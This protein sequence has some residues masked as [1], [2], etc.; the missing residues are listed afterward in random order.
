MSNPFRDKVLAEYVTQKYE[1]QIAKKC[2]V[3]PN[4]IDDFW[5]LNE[6]K[7]DK[8][9]KENRIRQR[10]MVLIYAGRIDKNKN[11]LLT[12]DM[13][14]KLIQENWNIKYIVVGR[15]EDDGVFKQLIRNSFVEYH[16]QTNQENLLS[17][18][19]KSDIFIMP[20]KS[21]TFG[22]VY[23]EAMSQ[24]LPVIYTRGQGFDG[25]YEEGVVGYSV[26]ANRT[27]D[28][29]RAIEQICNNYVT[30]SRTAKEKS[31]DYRWSKIARIY[32]GLYSDI[33]ER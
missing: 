16:T 10:K 13:I 23:A 24:G 20:S 26:S 14:S 25:Q 32:E 1:G 30:I 33:C 21:E 3:I 7:F 18:Y 28:I 22:L 19:R 31:R 15:N 4:G 8:V 17:Y 5:H 12:V 6:N 2:Y 11:L 27:E 9:E 29:I